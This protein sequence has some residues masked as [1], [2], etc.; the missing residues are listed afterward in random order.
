MKVTNGLL[1]VILLLLVANLCGTLWLIS[2]SSAPL[3]QQV[4]TS[5][6][7]D[8]QSFL[9]EFER[10]IKI[11]NNGEHEDIWGMF[12]EYARSQMNKENTVRS[13]LDGAVKN[14]RFVIPAQAAGVRSETL[15]LSITNWNFWIPA[16]AGMTT[17]DDV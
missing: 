7:I 16:F 13:I 10:S 2:K 5:G 1:Y 8:K 17:M 15:A 6:T 12:S 3:P 9:D 14:Q 11:Y 4:S